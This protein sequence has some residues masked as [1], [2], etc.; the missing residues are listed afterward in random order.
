MLSKAYQ[1][2]IASSSAIEYYRDLICEEVFNAIKQCPKNSYLDFFI[3]DCGKERINYVLNL[4]IKAL[5]GNPQL[6]YEDQAE[7]SRNRASEG[8]KFEETIA[9]IQIAKEFT[10]DFVDKKN[11]EAVLI[12]DAK[13]EL[14]KLYDIYYQGIIAIAISFINARENQINEKVKQLQSLHNFTKFI[15]KS[16]KLEELTKIF[17]SHMADIFQIENVIVALAKENKIKLYFGKS[18]KKRRLLILKTI[19]NTL[20]ERRTLFVNQSGCMSHHYQVNSFT[21]LISVPIEVNNNLLGVLVLH[22]TKSSIK[23]SEKDFEFFYQFMDLMSVSLEKAHILEQL[24]RSH[25]DLRML[26]QHII[27]VQEKER[28]KLAGDIHDSLAQRLTSINYKIQFF[29]ELYHVNPKKLPGEFD[30]AL[31]MSTDAIV[32]SRALISSLRPNLIDIIGLAPALKQYFKTFGQETGLQI[33][34]HH[35]S[36]IKLATNLKMCIFRVVQE[37]LINVNKHANAKNIEFSLQKKGREIHILVIDDG[38]GFN[39]EEKKNVNSL[40]IL[41]MKER[42]ESFGGTITI[43]SE[44]NKG[45]Q[46]RV[47][48]PFSKKDQ[49]EED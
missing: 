14:L 15:L 30:Y 26:A 37:T 13:K 12:L 39:I 45:C 40:G 29:K 20:D 9:P 1:M 34:V 18:T 31:K 28:K 25:D 19:R 44:I 6:F 5:D 49:N 4:I 42:I 27:M 24:G 41:L 10:I 46:V 35:F 23:L 17:Q 47:M 21:T 22:N 8:F 43:H 2:F 33:H 32:Q 11:E 16:L 3:Q 7:T 38:K 48:I 36:N